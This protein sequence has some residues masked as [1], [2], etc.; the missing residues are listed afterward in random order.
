MKRAMLALLLCL[1]LAGLSGCASVQQALSRVGED[2]EAA[3]L[4]TPAAG[5]AANADWSFVPV[6]RELATKTFTE[7]VPDATIRDT[8]VASKDND[9]VRAI[10]V[11]EYE[12]GG[13]TGSYGFDYQKNEQGEYELKRFGE[14]VRT[15]DLH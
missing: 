9:G 8:R 4:D 2:M 6:V 10:V 7:G 13:K 14:G 12:R 11:I 3:Y 15:D 5:S 1:A